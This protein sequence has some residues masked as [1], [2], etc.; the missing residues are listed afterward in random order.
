VLPL[1]LRDQLA[2]QVLKEHQSMFEEVLRLLKIFHQQAMLEMTHLLSTQMVI[3]ISGVEL[4]G[5]ALARLLGHKV[6]QDLLVRILPL[7]AQRVHKVRLELLVLLVLQ[8]L[9]QL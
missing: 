6:L 3:C 5:A 7:L 4:H 8:V 1:Q 9:I 2:Q